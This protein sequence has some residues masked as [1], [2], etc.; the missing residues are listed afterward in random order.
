MKYPKNTKTIKQ[1]RAAVS[2]IPYR[3]MTALGLVLAAQAGFL[4]SVQAASLWV[5]PNQRGND[6][7]TVGTNWGSVQ[8]SPGNNNTQSAYFGISIPDNW[9]SGSPT[10]PTAKIVALV[11]G[12]NWSNCLLTT[13]A[14]I[15]KNA[16]S[17]ALYSSAPAATTSVPGQNIAVNNLVEYDVSPVFDPMNV[18]PS[19]SYDHGHYVGVKFTVR[20]NGN[21][22]P[23]CNIVVEGL[24]ISYPDTGGG[25]GSGGVGPTG[26]T[27]A[28]G[29]TGPA[30]ATGAAGATGNPGPTGATGTSGINGVNGINGQDGATG[31]TGPTGPTGA[32]GPTGATGYTGATGATGP[33]GAAGLNGSTIWNG[34]QPPVP[35]GGAGDGD[36]YLD[37][38][39]LLLYGPY[40]SANAPNVW[41]TGLAIKGPT[42]VT[43]ATGA[44]GETGPTGATGSTGP[45]GPKGADGATGAIGPIGLAGAQ[46]PVGPTG[47]TGAQGPVGPTG[48]TGAT[49]DKG[50]TG[51]TG[52]TGVAGLNG[53]TIWSGVQSPVP[54]GGA[55]DGDFYLDTDDHLLYGPYVSA[56][57]LNAWGTGTS[58]KGPMGATGV[59]GATGEI[60]PT[61]ATGTNGAAGVA[62]PTGPTGPTGAT[63]T[64]GVAGVA[65][66]T[67]P[68]GAIGATGPAGVFDLVGAQTTSANDSNSPKTATA[69][70][71]G[72]KIA[73]SGGAFI[74]NGGNNVAIISTT[75]TSST[76]WTASAAEISNTNS[77]WSI[78]ATVIC[79]TVSP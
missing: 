48:P 8:L 54:G 9:D 52:A 58:I 11:K 60:G 76:D 4:P 2:F 28:T 25:G 72:G 49:G 73:I 55:N 46:G 35:G 24:K 7:G 41:G 47:D 22:G 20:R 67:G 34:N 14:S 45:T 17:Q 19:Y 53:N 74:T 43:G 71:T 79:A 29:A 37:T 75:R 57:G 40:V 77:N 44:T 39:T 18:T 51:A 78:T 13:T 15:S 12:N 70:C 63:G 30:G 68:T 32:A 50:A 23:G 65:G 3:S 42:G 16:S 66:P 38:A 61:G 62:G 33:T 26:P 64:N 56:N 1:G 27:G 59:T 21:N 10:P 31:P 36:F 69:S 5:A 6:T